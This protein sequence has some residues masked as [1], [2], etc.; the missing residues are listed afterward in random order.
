MKRSLVVFSLMAMSGSAF[1][2]GFSYTYAQ[3]NYGTVDIDSVSVDGD[4]LGL[5]GS[6]G[7]TDSLNIVG[8]WQ[9]ADFD[10]LADADEWSLG[11][12][13]HTPITELMDVTATVSYV[14]VSFDVLGVPVAEDDG[15]ELKV[16]LRA[17]VTSLIEVTAA[18]SYVD[19]S[20]GGDD[21]GFEGGVLYNFTDMFSV[22]LSGEWIDDV[23]TYSLSGRVY[24]GK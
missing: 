12:G 2:D 21:T 24:F 14:D 3:A 9:T 22:G 4:G 20:T 11:L 17:N 13:V 18:V 10:S 15:F 5:N 7:I 6:F 1:A 16:G 23:S 19:F 8:G